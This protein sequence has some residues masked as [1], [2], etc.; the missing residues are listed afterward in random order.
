[1]A[2]RRKKAT[3]RRGASRGA[4][5]GH[6]EACQKKGNES[7]VIVFHGFFRRLALKVNYMPLGRVN[8]T[9]R[10]WR[11][12]QRSNAYPVHRAWATAAANSDTANL[13]ALLGTMAKRHQVVVEKVRHSDYR[14]Q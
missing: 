11:V 4:S 13:R 14:I 6:R 3:R 8:G 10:C 1:M 7:A 12:R 9:C 5:S 2:G